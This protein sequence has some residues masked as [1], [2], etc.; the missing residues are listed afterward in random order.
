[1]KLIIAGGRSR[2]LYTADKE[3]LDEIYDQED[4]DVVISGDC[5]GVDEDG[6][7]WAETK[8][9]RVWRYPADWQQYG[10]RAGPIR[11]ETMAKTADAVVLFPGGDGTNSMYTIAKKYKIRIYD[12]RHIDNKE[13]FNA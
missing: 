1:M 9:I 3:L 6:A 11:N 10:K 7:A 12:Y 13:L 2:R 4:I 5:R 8:K